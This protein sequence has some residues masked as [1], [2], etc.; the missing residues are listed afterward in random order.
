MSLH[1]GVEEV[2]QLI[3]GYHIHSVVQIYMPGTGNNIQFLGFRS[4]LVHVFTEVP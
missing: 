1:A 4:L 3:P 2:R